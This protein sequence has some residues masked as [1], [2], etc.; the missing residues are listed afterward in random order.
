MSKRNQPE[1]IRKV[2]KSELSSGGTTKKVTINRAREKSTGKNFSH[3]SFFIPIPSFFSSYVTRKR[4]C[5]FTIISIRFHKRRKE[6]KVKRSIEDAFSLKNDSFP[7][8]CIFFSLPFLKMN[9]CSF[10]FIPSEKKGG[11]GSQQNGIRFHSSAKGH[12]IS[13]N[14][15]V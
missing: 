10:F 12:M 7:L 13:L 9:L 8:R 14:L 1:W 11:K 6:K 5:E 15:F 2:T 4:K 3:Y